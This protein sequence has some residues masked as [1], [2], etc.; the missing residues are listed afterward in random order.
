[1]TWATI[2]GHPRQQQH[3]TSITPIRVMTNVN[4]IAISRRH[5]ASPIADKKAPGRA[6]A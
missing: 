3:T 6:A 5:E 4:R 2:S 1:M